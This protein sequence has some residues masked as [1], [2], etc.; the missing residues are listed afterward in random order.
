MGKTVNRRRTICEV[1]RS[2]NDLHQSS[3]EIDIQTREL[4]SEATTYAKSMVRK[5]E[6][7]KSG[8][9]KEIFTGKTKDVK[10]K[11]RLRR[12]RGYIK[13]Q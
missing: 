5:L 6:E 11:K 13:I 4:L 9:K 3:S 10:A 2:I 1:L 7:Y 8:T 12:K